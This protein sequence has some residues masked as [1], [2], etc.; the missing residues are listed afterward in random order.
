MKWQWVIVLLLFPTLSV[1]KPAIAHG[2]KAEYKFTSAVEIKAQYDSGL[3]MKNAEITVYS[4]DN[5]TQ[6]WQTGMT[7]EKGYFTFKP[8]AS[9]T[10][11]WEV[12]VR[13][14]GHGTLISIPIKAENSLSQ[15]S[16]FLTQNNPGLTPLQKGVMIASVIWGCIGTALFFQRPKQTFSSSEPSREI[17]HPKS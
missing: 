11:Y 3:P 1:E 17:V 5:P 12:K 2:A 9:Q 10:G 8:D 4:P 13:Q 6:P 14:A 16:T 7:D 15:E